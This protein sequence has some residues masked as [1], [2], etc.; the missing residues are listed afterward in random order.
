LMLV[1]VESVK[2]AGSGPRISTTSFSG[3]LQ[4]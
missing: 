3:H 1:S 2:L 4:Y